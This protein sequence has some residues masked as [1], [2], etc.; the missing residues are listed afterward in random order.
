M[1]AVRTLVLIAAATL[2]ACGEKAAPPAKAPRD[3]MAVA[4]GADLQGRVR[5]EQPRQEDV[6]ETLRV[7]ARVEADETRMAR[8]GAPVAGRITDLAATI[9]QDVKRGQVLAT[10]NSTDLSTAQL[11][12]IRSQS[13]RA[14]AARAAARAQQLHEADV[15]AAVELQ[16]RQNE[17]TMADA[18]VGATRDQLKVLGMSEGALVRLTDT[19]TINSVAQIVASVS[20]TVIERKVTEGQVVQPA[21]TVYVVADLSRIWVVADIPE[22]SAGLVAVGESVAVEIAAFPGRRI[23]GALSFVSPIVSPET[24]T[25]RARIDLANPEREYKPAMLANMLIRGKAQRKLTV[26]AAAVVREENRDYVFVQA[27]PGRYVLKPVSL[28]T[29]YEERRAVNSGLTGEEQVVVEGAFH[30]NNERK[31]QLLE[32]N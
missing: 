14:Q 11:A 18:E 22:Q 8:V 2:A 17:L 23:P 21:D 3:P 32:G 19:R 12:Y 5:A 31:R 27:A 1:N 25:V 9:G 16:R 15:I 24:R 26:P 13:Q 4:A 6:R 20:G 28:G 7:P 30:L 29:E 10:I